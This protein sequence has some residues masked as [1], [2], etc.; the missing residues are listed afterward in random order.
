M[1]RC[2]A[3]LALLLFSPALCLAAAGKEG[4]QFLAEPGGV[5]S[6]AMGGAGSSLGG[7]PES[8]FLNP[9]LLSSVRAREAA[10]SHAGR[11]EGVSDAG[12]AYVHPLEE[13]ALAFRAWSRSY[14]DI[15]GYDGTGG[16]AA[17]YGARETLFSAGYG[18]S[19][20]G[21][22]M[23]AALKQAQ[24]SIAG[25]SAG[26]LALDA[27]L[28]RPW[29]G[30]PLSFSLG[31]RNLG[32]KASPGEEKAPLPRSLEAGV[33]AKL[34][35]GALLLALEGE[36]GSDAGTVWKAGVEAWAYNVVA[37]R[38]GFDGAREAGDGFSLGLGMKLKDLRVDYSFSPMG[39]ALGAVQRVGISFRFGGAGERLYQR[40]LAL[41][42]KGD[43]AE[44]V[45]R[46]KEALDA[47]PG[48]R[49]AARALRES[50]RR[51]E[52]ERS[53]K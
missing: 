22:G 3:A 49:E 42:Q 17:A 34:F 38:A 28:L 21:W 32:P 23:G 45:L 4:F 46:F 29:S 9:G 16:T 10:L 41:S 15:P 37:V 1:T 52:S 24:Q 14:G 30:T 7:D 33:G 25:R 18:R 20:R 12:A 8:V 51:L 31:V 47:D 35:S 43:H 26:V 40:G 39:E 44:A 27:G 36:G 53:V 6:A 50:I 2:A 5:R 19:F 11:P 13:G 48:H